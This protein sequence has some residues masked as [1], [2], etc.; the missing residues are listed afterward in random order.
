MAGRKRVAVGLAVTALIML[1]PGR[2]VAGTPGWETL[3]TP[4]PGTGHNVFLDVSGTSGSDVWAVGQYEVKPHVP[5]HALAAHWDGAT[6]RNVEVPMPAGKN[7]VDLAGV[8]AIAPDDVWAV[9][10]AGTTNDLRIATL[11]THWDG[12]SWKIVPSPNVGDENTPNHLTAVTAAGPD[13]VWAVGYAHQNAVSRPIAQHWDGRSWTLVPL[14]SPGAG[15]SVLSGV[16]AR[17]SDDVWA[18]GYAPSRTTGHQIEPYVVHFDGR[19]WT[20]VDT[21]NGGANGTWLTD[22]AVGPSGQVYAVGD[23]RWRTWAGSLTA[24]AAVMR[25][26]G[27]RWDYVNVPSFDIEGTSVGDVAIAPDGEVWLT[28]SSRTGENFA[29]L[30]GGTWQLIAGADP[31]VWAG[32]AHEGLTIA[33]DRVWMVGSYVPS[34]DNVNSRTYAERSP[35]LS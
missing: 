14:P 13:D 23:W 20:R 35:A 31:S 2:A 5:R 21:P 15:H 8:A 29:R 16:A 22:V 33:G 17:A 6:W 27:T 7:D 30:S 12:A 9:G 3:P 26:D 1:T 19:A 34:N 24:K 4:D 28:G 18:V 10:T 32:P 25:Y 11:I